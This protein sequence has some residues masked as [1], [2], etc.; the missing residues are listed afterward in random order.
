[1]ATKTDAEKRA[2][3]LRLL[4]DDLHANIDLT[5]AKLRVRYIS[6]AKEIAELLKAEHNERSRA[7]EAIEHAVATKEPA[8]AVRQGSRVTR[9][10]SELARLYSKSD[11]LRKDPDAR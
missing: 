4:V 2:A 7:E 9:E 3:R 5:S 10:Q 11:R 8:T 1:M 6:V